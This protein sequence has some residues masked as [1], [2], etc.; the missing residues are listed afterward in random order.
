MQASD[1]N[2]LL[3]RICVFVPSTWQVIGAIRTLSFLFAVFSN[4]SSNAVV[5]LVE[6]VHVVR[7]PMRSR[8]ILRPI[9]TAVLSSLITTEVLPTIFNCWGCAGISN[10]IP[11]L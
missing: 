9:D 1:T 7:Q 10:K 6:V 11:T 3:G 2:A 5:P 8:E 4:P